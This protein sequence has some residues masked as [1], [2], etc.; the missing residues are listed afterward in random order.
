MNCPMAS[1]KGSLVLCLIGVSVL[2]CIYDFG[3]VLKRRKHNG[4][5]SS[6]IASLSQDLVKIRS[7]K[8]H[9]SRRSNSQDLDLQ[10]VL[11]IVAPSHLSNKRILRR[12]CHRGIHHNMRVLSIDLIAAM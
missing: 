1:L 4:I 10:L 7:H 5:I 9:S 8:A 2:I 6:P 3:L 12:V 11:V